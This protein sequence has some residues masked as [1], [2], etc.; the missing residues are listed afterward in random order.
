[1]Y[2]KIWGREE[3]L[4]GKTAGQIV[5]SF[6]DI[7]K[8]NPI[9]CSEDREMLKKLFH[10]TAILALNRRFP[11]M[12]SEVIEAEDNKESEASRQTQSEI[13]NHAFDAIKFMLSRI[14]EHDLLTP[15]A[16]LAF[17][18]ILETMVLTH[19]AD[20]VRDEMDSV[21]TKL[22]PLIPEILIK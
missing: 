11:D 12:T 19:V 7:L 4:E 2:A 8:D 15:A 17:G 21:A 3:L 22:K 13:L 20:E 1:M 10:A 18:E 6:C 5:T 16:F 14:D 9:Y